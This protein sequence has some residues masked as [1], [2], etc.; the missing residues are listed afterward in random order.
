MLESKHVYR[1]RLAA[2]PIGDR[3]R[4]LDTLREREVAIRRNMPSSNALTS[5][6]GE[7]TV[8]H[9]RSDTG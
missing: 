9:Y 1:E 4:M 6:V 5:R 7:G 2:L 3:L 8:P